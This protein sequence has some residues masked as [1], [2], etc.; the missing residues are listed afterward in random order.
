MAKLTENQLKLRATREKKKQQVI[1]E[2][3]EV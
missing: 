2:K 1:R 3:M